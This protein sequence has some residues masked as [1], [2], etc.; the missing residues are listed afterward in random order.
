MG[1]DCRR[2]SVTF[3]LQ[4]RGEAPPLLPSDARFSPLLVPLWPIAGAPGG[5]AKYFRLIRTLASGNAQCSILVVVR[6]VLVLDRANL[7]TISFGLAF[8]LGWYASAIS[9]VIA[10]V[11][12]WF[13]CC[14]R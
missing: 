13:S 14:T 1:G 11:S 5:V 2:P 6:D 10:V 8:T 7:I 3:Y 9:G 12:S 4:Q